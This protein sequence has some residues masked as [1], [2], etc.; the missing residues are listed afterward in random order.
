MNCASLDTGS[1]GRLTDGAVSSQTVNCFAPAIILRE[2]DHVPLIGAGGVRGAY[3]RRGC[4]EVAIPIQCLPRNRYPYGGLMQETSY[5]WP[6][7]RR[8][9]SFTDL[10]G[11]N[12]RGIDRRRVDDPLSL[13]FRAAHHATEYPR[14]Y[15]RRGLNRIANTRC[16]ARCLNRENCSLSLSKGTKTKFQPNLWATNRSCRTV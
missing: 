16:A 3:L 2:F 6:G 9:N 10:Y 5:K 13:V 8:N 7:E 14:H 11:R 4:W 1:N 15:R 12:N